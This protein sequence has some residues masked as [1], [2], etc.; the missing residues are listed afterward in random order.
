MTRADNE[1][2][3]WGREWEK[4]TITHILYL[5]ISFSVLHVKRNH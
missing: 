3:E 2:A 4:T 5:E 1:V